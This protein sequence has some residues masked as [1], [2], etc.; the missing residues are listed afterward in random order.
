MTATIISSVIG[1]LV[2]LG[3]GLLNGK[4]NKMIQESE[5]NHEE[6]KKM[7]IAERECLLA[8]ADATVLMAK[9]LDDED[10]VNGELKESVTYLRDKKHKVQDL[11]R[12]IAFNRLED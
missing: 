7:S 6:H 1:G 5:A 9:K 2:A 4:L 10:S 12:E 3:F 8:V 11:T